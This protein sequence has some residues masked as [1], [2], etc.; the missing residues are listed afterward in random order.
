MDT[1]K[2]TVSLA[3]YETWIADLL[4][5]EMAGIG[6]ESFV[7]TEDGFEAFIPEKSYN[8]EDL[9]EILDS[10]EKGCTLTWCLSVVPAQ[11]WNEVW[12]KN[13]FQPLVISDMV[14]V[15]APFHTDYPLCPFEI[16]IEP[17]MAFGTG[18]HE[19]TSLMMEVMLEMDF[20]A[21]TVLDMGCGTGI[22]AVLASKLGCLT[23]TAIDNDPWSFKAVS[24][25]VIINNTLN[26]LP[27]LGDGDSIPVRTFD[28]ILVN[29]QRNV[30]LQDMEKYAEALHDGSYILFSGFYKEDLPAILEKASTFNLTL[31]QNSVKNNWTVAAFQRQ[32]RPSP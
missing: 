24:E 3:P 21:K 26:V 25:N 9:S 10:H 19:T 2:I 15:R 31:K 16:V 23:A 22:L 17:N 30:I 5:G 18:N 8:R 20:K 28:I 1:I 14:V 32:E 29:I 27:L 11:N 13:Y 7:E 12:E 6:F 4:M